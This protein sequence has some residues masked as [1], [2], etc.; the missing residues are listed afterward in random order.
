MAENQTILAFDVGTR[1]TGVAAGNALT[2]NAEPAGQLSVNQGQFNWIEVEKLLTV[3]QPTI[4]VIG[5]PQ[6]EAP[7]LNKVI[8]RL[9]HFLQTKGCKVV[10]IDER[11]SSEQS[12]QRLA[13]TS[14]KLSQKKKIELRD[15]IAACIILERYFDS[16]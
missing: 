15:Q 12:N 9:R 7:H 1:R 6:T 8:N 5:D 14:D 16:L 2:G 3:W 11:L 10:S 13:T 4:C